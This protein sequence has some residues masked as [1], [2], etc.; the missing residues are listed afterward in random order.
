ML[1]LLLLLLLLLH[2]QKNQCCPNHKDTGTIM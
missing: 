1:G 2:V